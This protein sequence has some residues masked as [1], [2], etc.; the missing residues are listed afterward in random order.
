MKNTK[1][2]RLTKEEREARNQK[3][4]D[5]RAAKKAARIAKR[6]AKKA[7]R[8]DKLEKKREKKRL[9]REA[10]KAKKIAKLEKEKAKKAALREKKRLAKEKAKA[11]EAAKKLKMNRRKNK[12]TKKDVKKVPVM[13]DEIDIREASKMMKGAF[14]QI[15][16]Q[17]AD[18]DVDKRIKKTKAIAGLGYDVKSVDGQI[19]IKFIVEKTK[20]DKTTVTVNDV[21]QPN[22]ND[23]EVAT[24]EIDDKPTSVEAVPMGDL[25]GTDGQVDEAEIA[26]LDNDES[27]VKNEDDILDIDDDTIVDSRD[28]QDQEL[29]EAREEYFANFSDDGE[30]NDI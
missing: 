1:K 15:A 20:K 3:L 2:V 9:T 27:D 12:P 26:N 7:A 24:P 6:E 23:P 28:E 19:V 18:L 25:M 29:I 16:S 8:L 30:A 10:A 5:E 17:M 14:S 13:K 4:K 21:E 11:L 22:K